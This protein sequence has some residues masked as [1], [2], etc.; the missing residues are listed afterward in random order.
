MHS[1]SLPWSPT[2]GRS[3]TVRRCGRATRG[4]PGRGAYGS[5]Y[6]WNRFAERSGDG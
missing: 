2:P 6:W 5:T 3:A 4:I 1:L